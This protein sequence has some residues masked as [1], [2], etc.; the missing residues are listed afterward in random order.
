MASKSVVVSFC[1]LSKVI[2][3]RPSRAMEHQSPSGASSP[4]KVS[5]SDVLSVLK[6]TLGGVSGEEGGRKG[7][8]KS[9]GGGGGARTCQSPRHCRNRADKQS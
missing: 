4:L 9:V 7:W 6:V 2:S 1:T 3:L 5:S 8:N